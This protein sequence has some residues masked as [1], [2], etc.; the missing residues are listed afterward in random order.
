MMQLQPDSC[1]SLHTLLSNT[2]HVLPIIWRT[3]FHTHIPKHLSKSK[4]PCDFLQWFV[5]SSPPPVGCSRLLIQ[6][7]DSNFRTLVTCLPVLQW[8]SGA[9]H[10]PLLVATKIQVLFSKFLS[11]IQLKFYQTFCR[12]YVTCTFMDC[13]TWRQHT[14]DSSHVASFKPPQHNCFES[15][16]LVTTPGPVEK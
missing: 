14:K 5:T 12:K 13:H 10:L 6:Y 11:K 7:T 16:G 9:P 15:T 4:A 8:P 1:T 3:K 2:A